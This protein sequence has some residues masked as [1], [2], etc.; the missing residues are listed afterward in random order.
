MIKYNPQ[1]ALQ[2]RDFNHDINL[3]RFTT[4]MKGTALRFVPAEDFKLLKKDDWNS[5]IQ[6]AGGII[7]NNKKQIL[8]VKNFIGNWVL[9]K[10]TVEKGESLLQ[11]AKRE[12]TE[13]T[14][15][16]DFKLNNLIPGKIIRPHYDV[17][18]IKHEYY[19]IGYSDHKG[20]LEP[21]E[22]RHIQSEWF[23]IDEAINK[24]IYKE[25]KEFLIN[26]KKL[27]LNSYTPP[28]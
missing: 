11:T 15:L 21:Q 5:I 22:E 14:G 12:I 28:L 1:V 3:I 6:R 16:V 13:E 26:N 4:G 23:E 27:I 10:G 18:V 8:I 19:F 17:G 2:I 24:L 9:P 7:L 20:P 25:Q